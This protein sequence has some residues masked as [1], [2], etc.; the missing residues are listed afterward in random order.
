ME[1]AKRFIVEIHSCYVVETEG[2]DLAIHAVLPIVA[3]AD[4]VRF[5]VRE[6]TEKPANEVDAPRNRYEHLTQSVYKVDEVAKILGISRGAVYEKVPCIRVGAR[7]LYPRATIVD[8]LENGLRREEP[9]IQSVGRRSRETPRKPPKVIRATASE[10]NDLPAQSQLCSMKEAS[11]MLRI[12]YAKAQELFDTRK[13]YSVENNGKRIIPSGAIE[14]FLVG[15]TPVQFVDVLIERAKTSGMFH[16]DS[17]GL[18][19]AA[20]ELRR[21]WTE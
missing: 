5:S 17:D 13:I 1:V 10:R 12:S 4:N 6:A 9:V 21:L 18:E 20:N 8:L 3:S 2:P 11:K 15:G 14:H 16:N 7:R 19:E